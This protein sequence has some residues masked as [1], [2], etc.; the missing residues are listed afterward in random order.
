M[1]VPGLANIYQR[2]LI[3]MQNQDKLIWSLHHGLRSDPRRA[4]SFGVTVDGTKLRVWFGCRIALFNFPSIDWLEVCRQRLISIPFL[5]FSLQSPDL[6]IKFFIFLAFSKESELGFDTQI[7]RVNYSDFQLHFLIQ[8]TDY[9]TSR[10]LYDVGADA[11]CGRGT[12]VF[13]AYQI[14]RAHV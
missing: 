10:V 12:W 3:T 5:I 13:E 6:L 11:M 1:Y 2:C 9:L 8:G 14:G 4:F 7:E